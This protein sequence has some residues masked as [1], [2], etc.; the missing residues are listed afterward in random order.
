MEDVS[1][2]VALR[3]LKSR[4][5]VGAAGKYQ[6]KITSVQPYEDK[7]IVNVN[8]MNLYQANE[9]RAL[10]GKEDYQGAIN[11]NLSFNVLSTSERM[12][13][14]G[15]EIY[16]VTNN[17]TLKSG[18]VALLISSW[19]AMPVSQGSSFN[20]EADAKEIAKE[21]AAAEQEFE[22]DGKKS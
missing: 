1:K 22:A 3:I 12:P 18:E 16:I 9:A 2:E 8:A 17:V 10:L 20:F 11:Q 19:S 7:H 21:L 5:I 6:V 15:E 4:T 13:V 14:R